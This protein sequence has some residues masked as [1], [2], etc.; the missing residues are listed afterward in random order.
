MTASYLLK[1]LLLMVYTLLVVSLLVFGITQL[2]PAD[3]AVTLLGQNATPEALAAVRERLGLD[4][5]AWLQYWHWLTQ[6]LQGNF[7]VSMRNGLEVA[8]TLLTALSRSL[9]LAVCALILMLIIA[10]PLGI[11]AAVRRGKTADVLVSV[12][13][14][15]G[16]SFPEFVTA[17][18]VLLL[19]ADV[20]QILPATGYVPLS[21]NFV[22][23]IQHL[24]LPSVTVALILV[25]HVSRMVRSEMVDVLHT[26]YIRAAWL[27]GLSRRRILWRH[28]L[29]NGLLPT[30][31]IVALDVGYLLGGIVVVE[32]IF[33][34]PGIG[35]ELIVAV[36][37]RDLPTIQAGVM[38]L[39][40]TY[41]VVNFLAD[42]A[43]VTLD[44]RISYA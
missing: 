39:A 9:L 2:L 21:E 23:G 33:A 42:L 36:Q 16:I 3:A 15:I 17:T 4:A 12:I 32:E 24:I 6:A 41:S 10:I 13:S 31:T 11:W 37:A 38:I 5:P 26:D 19:F 7:G 35:R 27:K 25:A 18:L 14:Y 40:A 44:K 20:W 43:Y 30:I 29:R 22:S 1:R 28:A 34:I 8:P